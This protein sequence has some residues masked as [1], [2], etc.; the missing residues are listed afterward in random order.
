MCPRGRAR[1]PKKK[2]SVKKKRQNLQGQ[3]EL[4]P[5]CLVM[6]Y[7]ASLTHSL[8][9]EGGDH[10]FPELLPRHFTAFQEA[11]AASF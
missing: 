11:L 4:C 3:A 10:S 9:T 7:S 8:A 2:K 5:H 6:L 1:L